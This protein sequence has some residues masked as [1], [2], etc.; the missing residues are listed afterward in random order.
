MSTTKPRERKRQ[1]RPGG[2]SFFIVPVL[3]LVLVF[4]SASRSVSESRRESAN[5]FLGLAFT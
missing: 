3:L 2:L 1:A 5:D 4:S